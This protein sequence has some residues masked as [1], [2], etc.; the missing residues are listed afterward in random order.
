MP[1]KTP[2]KIPEGPPIDYAILFNCDGEDVAIDWGNDPQ[3]AEKY[4][5]VLAT[6]G[7]V[8]LIPKKGTE[9]PL[10][11]MSVSLEGGKRWI[12]FSKVIGQIGSSTKGKQIRI[13]AIG[14]QA[15][16]GGRNVKSISWVYPDGGVE[17]SDDPML[18]RSFLN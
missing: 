2:N 12:V 3:W 16:V 7:R 4:K 10:P 6:A 1:N 15:T 11:P 5:N 8:W 17:M 9:T 14:W 13:Y 18:Y